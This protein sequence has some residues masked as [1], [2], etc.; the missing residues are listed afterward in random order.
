MS[1]DLANFLLVDNRS[2]KLTF[3]LAVPTTV[4]QYSVHFWPLQ[5]GTVTDVS[6]VIDRCKFPIYPTYNLKCMVRTQ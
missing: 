2:S 6:M 4:V 5:Y 3:S 1:T